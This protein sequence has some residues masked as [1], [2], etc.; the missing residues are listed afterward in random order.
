MCS[1]GSCQLLGL[2][3]EI[4]PHQKPIRKNQI[5]Q[6]SDLGCRSCFVITARNT[7]FSQHLCFP[8][9]KDKRGSLRS[10][11]EFP[12][13]KSIAWFATCERSLENV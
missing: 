3:Y 6:L 12:V 5:R 13:G 9:L 7:D 2:A 8:I 10:G 1:S 4:T 11:P